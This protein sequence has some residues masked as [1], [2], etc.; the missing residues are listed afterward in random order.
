MDR[1]RPPRGH[2][3]LPGAGERRDRHQAGTDAE[4]V[5][6]DATELVAQV[7]AWLQADHDPLTAKVLRKPERAEIAAPVQ[8]QLIVERTPSSPS[9]PAR[10]CAAAG[11]ARARPPNLRRRQDPMLDFQIPRITAESVEDNHG[12][13]RGGAARSRLRLHLRQLTAARAPCLARRCGGDLRSHQ[14]G[15][16][17]SSRRSRASPRT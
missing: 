1:Q 15:S 16:P 6:R 11:A 3:Q 2:P 10:P 8:E 9:L 4:T 12:Q 17:A 13:F 5:V 7:P 14:R